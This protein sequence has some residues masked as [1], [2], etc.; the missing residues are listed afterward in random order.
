MLK[1]YIVAV[2]AMS[3]SISREDA[4]ARSSGP[5]F[6]DVEL[7]HGAMDKRREQH[8]E[9]TDED[10]AGEEGVERCEDLRAV[11][12]QCVDGTHP[13]EDHRRVEERIDPVQSRQVVIASHPDVQRN[14]RRS[15]RNP[16]VAEHPPGK[17]SAGEQ[18][19]LSAF[20][21]FVI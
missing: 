3:Y 8:A 11:A 17:L 1:R 5:L 4:K 20:V 13:A 18:A 16:D 15:E 21:H 10:Q 7:V 19:I 2:S 6:V 12:F 9:K 14:R